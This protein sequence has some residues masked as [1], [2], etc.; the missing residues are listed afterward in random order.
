MHFHTYEGD[1]MTNTLCNIVRIS[2]A[3]KRADSIWWPSEKSQ[4]CLESCS[5]CVK[6][7]SINYSHISYQAV[8]SVNHFLFFSSVSDRGI[9]PWENSFY[10]LWCT[11]GQY[12]SFTVDFFYMKIPTKCW[13]LRLWLSTTMNNCWQR[14]VCDLL[15]FLLTFTHLDG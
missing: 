6:V 4:S 12:I 9:T 3:K 15:S 13:K 14:S 2:S 5:M 1:K 8:F 11:W 10:T 7:K